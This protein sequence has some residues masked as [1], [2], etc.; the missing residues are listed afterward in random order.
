MKLILPLLI[1]ILFSLELYSQTSISGGSVNGTWTQAGS[2]YLIEGEISIENG[3]SLRIEPGVSVE[4]QG[5]YKF[6][7]QGQIIAKGTEADSIVFTA[8]HPSIGWQ[9]IRF[10]ETPLT[11]DTSRFEYC[12]FEH[13]RVYDE[14][15]DN[16]GGAI[17]A[18]FFGKIIIDHCLF[19][20]NIAIIE[21]PATG[22]PSGGAIALMES[23]PVIRNSKFI[24]NE[25]HYGGAICCYIESNPVIENNLFSW[26]YAHTWGGAILCVVR[27]D[28]KISNNTF[29]LNQSFMYGG[30]IL[31][32]DSCSP[33]IEYNLFYS[34]GAKKDG[35]AIEMFGD[36]NPKIINNTIANNSADSVGGGID[37]SWDCSPEIRNTILWGNTA[38]NGNQV[39][40]WEET[41][42]P[43]FYYS[44]IQGG[45]SSIGGV[46][47]TG[48]YMECID[49][50]PLFI[51]PLNKNYHLTE[52]SPCIDAGDPEMF[53][54]D[55]TR[56]DIG[57]FY[58]NQA[59]HTP[60]AFNATNING[61]GFTGHWSSCFGALMYKLDVAY[62][63]AFTNFVGEYNDYPVN[64]TL[65]VI[66]GVEAG[67]CY[68]RVR[69]QNGHFTSPNSNTVDVQLLDVDELRV[70]G[71][72]LRVF[73]NPCSG[74][75]RLRYLISDSGYLISDLYSISGMKIRE[76][77]NEM[78]PAGEHE[79][80]MDVS[81]L[82][83]GVYFVRV[84][85]G[86][87]V[88]VKK[89]LVVH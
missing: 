15:P 51:D 29:T 72:G 40:I 67:V 78:M 2:P 3:D 85:A 61:S 81:D 66:D 20:R 8:K 12:V 23:S 75:A 21:N 89:L 53:D 19:D 82:P 33:Q 39:Y 45:Q 76:L 70:T 63:G 79:I 4:F 18:A 10:I 37:I 36:C 13:G 14:W 32:G 69:S 7:V 46:S 34:N 83:D 71:C 80:E 22:L 84:Q 44:D 47:I 1:A 58:Y 42:K 56:S 31:C 55:G 43:N 41:C 11:N 86:Q 59:L 73:P 25:S 49:L 60:T 57:V 87:E 62:D 28:P 65:I 9:S 6:I 38:I 26:N 68:Y 88:A 5:S 50:D 52:L 48:E 17:G 74:A 27:S 77:V 16:C 30:A 35:G 54:P 24:C 64:D